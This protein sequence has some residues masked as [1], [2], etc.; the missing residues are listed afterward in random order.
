MSD[1]KA[2]PYSPNRQS[3]AGSNQPKK[4]NHPFIISGIF[5]VLVKVSL[6]RRL[7]LFVLTNPCLIFTAR[8]G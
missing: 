8:S 7:P 1:Y 5:D 3:Q 4:R 6:Y 2:S